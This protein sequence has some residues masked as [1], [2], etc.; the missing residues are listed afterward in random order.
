MVVEVEPRALGPARFRGSLARVAAESSRCPLASLQRSG[1]G[2]PHAEA[3]A[4][5]AQP[6]PPGAG[7]AAASQPCSWPRLPRHLRHA[8]SR[9][10]PHSLPARGP[11][12]RP[13][14]GLPGQRLHPH[15]QQPGAHASRAPGHGAL[16]LL[17]QLPGSGQQRPLCLRLGAHAPPEKQET[18]R[19]TAPEW[20]R[21]ATRQLGDTWL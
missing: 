4:E 17:R 7:L 20:G 19:G 13:L 2:A 11:L 21:E 3:A 5:P 12:P 8:D 9:P 1:R 14:P 10:S 18:V 16:Q 15:Q 6:E